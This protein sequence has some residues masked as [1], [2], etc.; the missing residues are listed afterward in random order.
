MTNL[1][2]SWFS[3]QV[4]GSRS[5]LRLDARGHVIGVRLAGS[6]VLWQKQN[7]WSVTA[8]LS[9]PKHPTSEKRWSERWTRKV[10]DEKEKEMLSSEIIVKLKHIQSI[11]NFFLQT[12]HIKSLSDKVNR[13]INKTETEYK[14]WLYRPSINTQS[15]GLTQGESEE[16]LNLFSQAY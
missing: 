5:D 12:V 8:R 2:G 3:A 11:L 7:Q 14:H 1:P 15:Q 4:S 16:I 9:N 6:H 10:N 13:N